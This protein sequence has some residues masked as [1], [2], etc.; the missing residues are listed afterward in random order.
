MEESA[1][2]ADRQTEHT[3][4]DD[5]V[6]IPSVL[7]GIYAY[8]YET[9]SPIQAQTI[10][11]ISDKKNIIAQSQSGTGKTAC[12]VV[13][14]LTRINLNKHTTQVLI[15]SPTREL[16]TQ[17][18]SVVEGLSSPMAGL[19][20]AL[21]VGG[22]PIPFKPFGRAQDSHP[23]I[24]VGCPG[25]ILDLMRRRLINV[26][27]LKMLVMDEADVLISSKFGEQTYNILK[28][29]HHKNPSMQIALFSATL[30]PDVSDIVSEFITDP[31]SISILPE[32]ISL[33]GIKQ[34]YIPVNDDR[35]KYS[36]IQDLYNFISVSQCI[37]YCNNVHR[38]ID[39]YETM[40]HDDFPVSCIHS[41]MDNE[42]R[43]KAISEFRVGKSRVMVSS[44]ITSRGIDIQQV[45]MVINFDIPLDVH[46]Y[47]HR[48]GR[49]GRWGRKGTA[50]NLITRR[51]MRKMKEIE[52][53]YKCSIDEFPSNYNLI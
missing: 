50:I 20:V 31:V 15:L 7:R 5:I 27:T 17:I 11:H 22:Q 39:L 3:S 45:N 6:K 28:L 18:C 33:D 48:I 9:P 43:T 26:S 42:Q 32:K 51:N 40:M 38:V 36:V 30:P 12:F 1:S 10:S 16:S 23:H 46:T 2:S 34:Y 19:T 37:I 29:T 49:S 53:Y 13:G 25:R 35:M 21:M 52:D 14:A 8:G 4:W 41:N 47:I 44:D 24:V